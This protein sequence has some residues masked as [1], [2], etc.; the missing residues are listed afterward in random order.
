MGR[1]GMSAEEERFIES[2]GLFFERQGVPR[3][4]GRILGLLLLADEPLALGEIAR[5]LRVSPASVSTNIRQLQTSGTV[6]PASIP[7][8]RRH[9][10]VFNSVGWDHRLELA[11]SAMD[12]LSR[13]CQDALASPGRGKRVKLRETVEFCAFY[14]EELS[15]AAER[16]RARFARKPGTQAT[17]APSPSARQRRSGT[18]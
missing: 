7:G 17:R 10:Y 1:T 13:L 14:S 3:I 9:Y 16:W 18:R 15:G 5:L 8:D 6:E 2:M 11:V 4:G 12:A